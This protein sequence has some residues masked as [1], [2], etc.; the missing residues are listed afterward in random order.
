MLSTM[1]DVISFVKSRKIERERE[2]V[3]YRVKD[4]V[5]V[6][7]TLQKS[8][9]VLSFFIMLFIFKEFCV[10]NIFQGLAYFAANYGLSNE[11]VNE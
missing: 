5:F 3:Q 11:G 2:V 7:D 1:K 6:D 9:L 8:C 10:T 4:I